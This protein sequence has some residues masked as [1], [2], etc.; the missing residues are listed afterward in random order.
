MEKLKTFI[1]AAYLKA[2]SILT[3]YLTIIEKISTLIA[4]LLVKFKVINEQSASLTTT[5]IYIILHI[6]TLS[7]ICYFIF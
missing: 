1:I 4:G 3:V 2:H 7:I 6:T 5:A